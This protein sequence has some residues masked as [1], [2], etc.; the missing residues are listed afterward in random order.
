[1]GVKALTSTH[2][3]PLADALFDAFGSVNEL[4]RLLHS[5]EPAKDLDAITSRAKSFKENAWEIVAKAFEEGWALPLLDAARAAQPDNPRLRAL[6]DAI[7]EQGTEVVGRVAK[8]PDRPSL[9]CGRTTQWGEI[10]QMAPAGQHQ[11]IL[12]MGQAGQ[13]PL[14][15]RDRIH[16]WLATEPRR[17]MVAVHWPTRPASPGEFFEALGLA[18]NVPKEQLTSDAIARAS[19]AQ[20]IAQRLAGQNLVLLHPGITLKFGDDKLIK[21]YTEWLPELVQTAPTAGKLKCV[22]PI[23]WPAAASKTFWQRLGFGGSAT[24][25]N[26]RQSA[27]ALIAA[28]KSRQA[29][30]VHV[31]EIDELIDLTDKDLRTFIENSG[32]TATQRKTLLTTIMGGSRVPATIFETID[33]NWNEVQAGS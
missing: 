1:M 29:A 16:V 4:D 18:L 7:P 26:S 27:L 31:V 9:L 24:D 21:Y 12:V 32:L 15:F 20:A 30:A 13:A 28:L 23:E 22:Q 2:L 14:H 3:G 25:P 19:V 33:A 10:C 17:S 6:W 8:R 11:V 5:L